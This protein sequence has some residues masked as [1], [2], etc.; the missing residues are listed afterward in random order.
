M[1][2]LLAALDHAVAWLIRRIVLPIA[3][4]ALAVAL[5]AMAAEIVCRYFLSFSLVW[6]E[7]LSRYAI[8]WSTMLGAPV[9]YYD[10]ES[11]AVTMVLET[12]PA[13]SRRLL[14]PLVHSVTLV[15]GAVLAVAGWGLTARNFARNQLMTALELPIAW[16]NL[17]VPVGGGLLVLVGLI[18]LLHRRPS[19]VSAP[20][21]E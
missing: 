7:E 10:G 14:V 16:V 3:A 12:F 4:A 18:G 5:S 2:D 8:I 19:F 11:I 9:A 6:A 20:L 21:G 1:T 13:L 15:F 17:A